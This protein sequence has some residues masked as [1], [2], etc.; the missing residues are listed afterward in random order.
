M[1]HTVVP[2]P[3]ALNNAHSLN[4]SWTNTENRKPAKGKEKARYFSVPVRESAARLSF[5]QSNLQD[6]E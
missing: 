5:Y 3:S 1:L 2:V 4:A 6:A